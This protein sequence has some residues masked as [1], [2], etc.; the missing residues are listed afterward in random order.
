V[1]F[2]AILE[3]FGVL[4]A[5][6]FARRISQKTS[7][8]TAAGNSTV[9]FGADQPPLSMLKQSTGWTFILP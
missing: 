3:V 8:F 4:L 9:L 7:S 1:S 2:S 5:R 6:P